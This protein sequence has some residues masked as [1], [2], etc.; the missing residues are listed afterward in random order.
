MHRGDLLYPLTTNSQDAL[1]VLAALD[2]WIMTTDPHRI[3]RTLAALGFLALAG[4]LGTEMP[5]WHEE[6]AIFPAAGAT[7][8]LPPVEADH[9]APLVYEDSCARPTTSPQ[10]GASVLGVRLL[11]SIS[12][13][14]LV[15]CVGERSLPVMVMT[16][17]AGVIYWP[18][19]LLRFWHQDELVPLRWL[20]MFYV[21]LA[22]WL[23]ML[24]V[25]RYADRRLATMSMLL[26]SVTSAALFVGGLTVQYEVSLWLCTVAGILM[27]VRRQPPTNTDRRRRVSTIRL[28]LAGLLLGAALASSVKCVF[29]WLPLLLVH[30]RVE[31]RIPLP[32]PR[33]LSVFI[34]GA[35]V[36]LSPLLLSITLD[37]GAG[38]SAQ[39]HRR[40]TSL[41]AQLSAQKL[42]L[43]AQNLA[44]FWADMHFYLDLAGNRD[45]TPSLPA[46]FVSFPALAYSFWAAFVLLWRGEHRNGPRF[47]A[48][49]CGTIFATF[50][51]VST[52]LY[53]QQPAANYAP[54][55]AV[56]GVATAAALARLMQTLKPWIQQFGSETSPARWRHASNAMVAVTMAALLYS[57]VQR[58]APTKYVTLGFN[59]QAER[60]IVG[61]LTQP[62]TRPER[63]FTATYNLAGTLPRLMTSATPAIQAHHFLRCLAPDNSTQDVAAHTPRP[64]LVDRLVALIQDQPT[65]LRLLAPDTKQLM[66]A[67]W[68]AELATGLA[69]AGARTGRKIRLERQ[70]HTGRGVT[71]LNL[72]HVGPA[73]VSDE[74]RP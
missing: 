41:L 4:W 63:L 55:F 44:W 66:D 20:G 17:A 19:E 53:E 37:D 11:R 28:G 40:I 61:Y 47:V 42:L 59:L 2:A 72:W 38:V 25:Q 43:E 7:V 10:E 70:G 15:L 56:F 26:M 35:L 32:K 18:L 3:L 48:G 60:E 45:A 13:P 30:R 23:T 69:Q 33:R 24:L 57:S 46:L 52:L 39:A 12:R 34:V 9:P 68:T 22:L 14:R 21:L 62:S 50:L 51:L 49:V 1:P 8:L 36:G 73:G 65:P 16:Y 58:G 6:S 54:I 27:L 67:A 74:G 71:V 5:A 29:F 64:C 31:G